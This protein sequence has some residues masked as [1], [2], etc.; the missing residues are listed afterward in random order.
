MQPDPRQSQG[1]AQVSLFQELDTDALSR[2]ESQSWVQSY[3]D[4][5]VLASEGEPGESLLVLESGQ[6]KISRFTTS[7]QE[8]VLAVVEAPDAIGELA[9]LDG[10]PRS[11]TITALTPVEIRIVP[12]Q[13]FQML[14]E[15]EPQTMFLVLRA[16][17][18]MVRATN[19]RLFDILSLDEIGRAHV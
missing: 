3:P 6:V 5:Q 1:L 2:L 12:R 8:V 15:S 13:A 11:A 16:L 7:G 4:G 18:G 14:L 10:A 19:E 17:A 9:L